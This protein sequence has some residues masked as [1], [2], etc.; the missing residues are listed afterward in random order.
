MPQTDWS[1]IGEDIPLVGEEN[2]YCAHDTSETIHGRD[3][4]AY[5]RLQVVLATSIAKFHSR[6]P[7]LPV[8]R[9]SISSI[10]RS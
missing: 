9:V 8:S 3:M 1:R 10:G 5:G 6:Q 7:G 4:K 2:G